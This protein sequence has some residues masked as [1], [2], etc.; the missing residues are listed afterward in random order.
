MSKE[1]I[2]EVNNVTIT[3]IKKNPPEYRIDAT[4]KTATAGWSKAELSAV[5]YVQPPPDG[6]YDYQFVAEP[7]SNVSSQVLTPISAQKVLGK[8]PK[9]FR[10]VRVQAV[11]NKKEALLEE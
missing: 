4:G 10:G 5:V 2:Y 6:I 1:L 11:S 3:Y 7:P 8:M 9:G